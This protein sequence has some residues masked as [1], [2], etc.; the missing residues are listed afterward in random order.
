MKEGKVV[1][2]GTH[3]R[4]MDLNG[5]YSKMFNIQA[6]AFENSSSSSVE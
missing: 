3:S 6:Q 1:E 4:L 5:E 2:S